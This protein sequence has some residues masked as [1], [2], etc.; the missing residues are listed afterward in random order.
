MKRVLIFALTYHPFVGGA[1][2][3]MK[4]ITNRLDP[5]EYEFDMITL[6]FNSALP[7]IEK[8]GNIRVHRIGPAIANAKVS[9]RNLPLAL[10]FG[11]LIFPFIAYW[12]A[13]S[14]HAAETYDLVWALMANQA[15]F[16]ALFF[17]WINP[18]I[19]YVLELQDGRAL[20]DMTKRRSMLRFLWPLFKSVYM[21]ADKIKAISHFIERDV[22]DLGYHGDIAVIP[23]A[24]DVAAFS[25]EIPEDE[26]IA[27]KAKLKKQMGDIFLFTA[28]RLV[29]SRGVEDTIRALAFLPGNVKLL[30]AGTGDDQAK[31][32]QIAE[33]VKVRDRVQFLGHIDHVSLPSYY[34][35]SDIFVRPS[36]IEGFG[37]AFVEAFAAGIPVVATPVGGIPDFL[38]D[39]E[40]DT[41]M[42]PTGVFCNVHDPESVAHAVKRYMED[43][44]LVARVKKNALELA[45]EKYDWTIVVDAMKTR[46]FEPLTSR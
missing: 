20:S 4:E 3:A 45:R 13:R 32:E 19:P 38:F 40:R 16:A 36:V 43:P 7:A 11:K 46:L 5:H 30:I 42:E 22:R 39:P 34:K 44:L 21:R 18:R 8:I 29:L 15:G 10:R 27:L 25:R 37:N 14:L 31:L 33:T 24:V 1:E 26:I 12:K 9:D 2:V 41:D 28:S 23:N 17:K 35:V 6:R